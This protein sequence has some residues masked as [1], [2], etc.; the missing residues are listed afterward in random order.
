MI[1]VD[2][3]TFLYRLKESKEYG[4]NKLV[5]WAREARIIRGL[6]SSFQYWK[7]LFFFVSKDEWE[8][9]SSEVWGDI[10]RLLHWW[11]TPSL[12]ASSFRQSFII[13]IYCFLAHVLSLLTFLLVV[14]CTVKR[15]PKLKSRYRQC[16]EVAI[17][18]ARTIEDFGDPVNP[19]TLALH[20]LGP[21]PSAII[22]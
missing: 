3:F 4:Y 20:C 6:P 13:I 19:R 17:E 16:V 18:Y 12:G 8:T 21:K 1:K 5:R 14:S 11:G 22:L 9:P 10:P 2:E 15:R 7:S